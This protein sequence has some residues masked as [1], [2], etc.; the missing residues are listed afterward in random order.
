MH[1]LGANPCS[2]VFA[3]WCWMRGPQRIAWVPEVSFGATV[4][5]SHAIASRAAPPRPAPP[6]PP[7]HQPTAP[8]HT[9]YKKPIHV[10]TCS[11]WLANEPMMKLP[12]NTVTTCRRADRDGGVR[13][14]GQDGERNETMLRKLPAGQR[15]VQRRFHPSLVLHCHLCSSKVNH[16]WEKKEKRCSSHTCLQGEEAGDRPQCVKL[17]HSKL[18]RMQPLAWNAK[19]RETTPST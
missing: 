3:M 18:V 11:S 9:P 17:M 13:R 1:S 5:T 14:G 19:R 15:P 4:G 8:A 2:G 7:H 16:A 10:H 6:H 12:K